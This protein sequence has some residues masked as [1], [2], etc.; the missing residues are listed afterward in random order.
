M[1]P[2]ARRRKVLVAFSGSVA[3]IKAVPLCEALARLS[4][5]DGSQV[6]LTI[7]LTKAACHFV[8][9]DALRPFGTVYTDED[10]WRVSLWLWGTISA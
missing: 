7:V 2:V 3:S 10:E 8:E 9:P 6:T 4:L 5:G 1:E